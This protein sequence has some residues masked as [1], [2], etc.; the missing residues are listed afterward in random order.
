MEFR[1]V[2]AA[3]DSLRSRELVRQMMEQ[4]AA[5]HFNAVFV[6][7][8]S[9]GYPLWPS[10]VFARETGR[11]VDPLFAGRDVIAE[12]LEEARPFGIAVFPW[13]EYGFVGGWAGYYPGEGGRG[14]IFDHRPEW[15]AR[16]RSGEDRFPNDFFWMAH[17]HPGVQQFLI[18]LTVEIVQ[19]YDVPGVQFDRARYPQLDCGYDQV[20]IELYRSEHGGGAPPA[21]PAEPGWVAWRSA[22][23]DAFLDALY[24]AVKATDWRALVANAPIVSPFGYVNFAQNYPAWLRAR[25][26]D[27]LSPQV[28][29]A[30]TASFV[31]ELD[32]QLGQVADPARVVPGID[33]TNSR[34][35]GVLSEMVAA[36]RARRL[37]GFTIWYYG[38]LQ[39]LGVWDALREGA[40]RAPARLPFRWPQ[41]R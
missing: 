29:R 17:A 18:G 3:R 37:P 28:Y 41:P 25:S 1:G 16:T 10:E 4:L 30:T 15:L 13:L 20:T 24:R 32:R 22:K 40:L 5:A 14:P 7:V 36:V 38:A 35:V 34:D 33:V 12:A 8:W 19:R 9:R 2:W 21:N 23:L 26:V 39:Q 11:S 31:A 6:N 27:F